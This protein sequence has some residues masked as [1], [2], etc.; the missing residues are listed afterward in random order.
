MSQRGH[1]M[2]ILRRMTGMGAAGSL[3]LALLAGGC[4]L[5]ATAGPRQTAATGTRVLRQTIDGTDPLARTVVVTTN[6][7]T[8][9]GDFGATMDR[10]GNEVLT[11]ADLTDATG[12]LRRDFGVDA[13]PLAPRSADWTGMTTEEDLLLNPP[14]S[15]NGVTAKVEV[16]YRDPSAGHLRLLAGSMPR[17]PPPATA[18]GNPLL[19]VVVTPQTARTF[20]LRLGSR[21]AVIGPLLTVI[22]GSRPPPTDQVYLQVTGIVEPTDPSSTFWTA[23]S[24]LAGPALNRVGQSPLWEG[25]VIADPGDSGVLQE[26]FGAEGVNIQ[27]ELPVNAAGLHGQAPALL[28]QL[29]QI[30]GRTPTLTGGL[31]PMANALSVSSGL[32]TPL[33]AVV[34]ASNAVN[35]LL[36]MVYMGLLVAGVVV[37]LLAARMIAVR[38]SAELALRRSRGASLWQLLWLGSLGAAVA[39][40]PAAALAWALAVLLIPGAA[41]AGVAAWWPGIATLAIAV[42][43]PGVVAAWQHRL[44]RRRAGGRAGGRRRGRWAPRVIAEVTA[45]AAAVGGLVVFRGQ[46][47]ATDVYTSAA[48]VLVAIPAVVVV[49]RLYPLLLRGLARASAR[50][51][52]VIG[53][54]GLA[55][56]ARASAA[57][58]L[59]AMTLVLVITV[60]AFTSMVRDAVVSG[61][62]AASWQANGADV[63]LTVPGLAGTGTGISPAAIRA[64]TAVPGVQHAAT[65]LVIALGVNEGQLVTAIGVDPASYAALVASTPGFSP[66]DASLLAPPRGQ[67]TVPVLASPQAAAAFGGQSGPPVSVP[68]QGGLAALRLR[69]AGTLQSTPALPSGLPFIV[70]PLAAMRGTAGPPLVNVMLLTGASID[71]ARLDA[72]VRATMPGT[73][74]PVITTRAQVLQGLAGTPLQQG[75]FLLFSLAIG[76]AAALA[77]AVMLLE[78]ALGAAERELTLARLATMGLAEGQ[79]VRLAALEVLPA[80]AAAAVAAVACAIVLPGLV[81]PAIDLSVFTQSQAPVPLRPD[82]ASFLLPLAG[83]LVVTVI[84]LGYEISSARGR[85]IAVSMRG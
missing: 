25:A 37:L 30:T 4:V 56:A 43:G 58:T 21:M 44:P 28:S 8:V 48:P 2:S 45:C 68:A 12:Q 9:N 85:G 78:L 55:R 29:N 26:V 14:A 41:P 59:P 27:W 57:L 1:S 22:S 79:R 82:V 63:V 50:R 75:T 5:A 19:Q 80:V 31:A 47:G 64:V 62:T 35:V 76:F 52:G 72:A 65:A 83:L 18:T 23:D 13:L 6:W 67:G 77:L 54:V 66:V 51:R 70:V 34:Q 3:A 24:L 53:L 10:I 38:R 61:E 69:V 84:A 32:V 46:P 74:T 42:A 16:A 81:A 33:A 71:M 11:P 40:L 17:T 20:G 7:A 36:W 60:A 39:C 49:L 15:L 73:D